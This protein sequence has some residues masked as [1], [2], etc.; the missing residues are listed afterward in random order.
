MKKKLL[1]HSNSSKL[2]TGFGRHM[3]TILSYLYS[4]GK[5]ELV[6]Y[7]AAPFSWS[8]KRL[9]S[10]PWK[11]FGA[12]PDSAN[13]V[14]DNL[15][16]QDKMLISYGLMN[17]DRVIEQEK[18]DFYFGIEDIWGLH[19]VWQRPWFNKI[20]SVLW[21]PVDSLPLLPLLKEAA[22]KSKNLWVKADFAQQELNKAGFNQVITVPALIDETP[23]FPLNELAR[24]QL[25]N[26]IGIEDDVFIVGFVFRNQI[27]KLVG[28]LFD[29]LR[30][31]KEKNPGAKIKVLLHTSWREGW[32]IRKLMEDIGIDH[33]D[34]ITSY[35]CHNC[36]TVQIM[37]YHGEEINC[38]AC[39][40]KALYTVDS[41]C[42]VTE[43]ELNQIY[44]LCDQY[45]HP[46]TSGGFEMPILE[47]IYAGVPAA[48]VPYSCGLSYTENKDIFPIEFTYY[49]DINNSQFLKS[50]PLPE[51]VADSFELFYNKTREE[52]VEIA[53]R[54]REWALDKFS[55]KKWLAKLEE[56]IDNTPVTNYD[57][58]Y[59]L[60]ANEEYPF[61]DNPDSRVFV[62]DL[63]K[64]IFNT[65][66]DDNNDEYKNILSGIE[67]GATH[68]KVYDEFITFA[69]QQNSS[70]RKLDLK[71]LIPASDNKKLLYVIPESLGDCFISLSVIEAII[72]EYVGWDIF[73]AS[74]E[75]YHDVF[76]HIPEVKGILKYEKW[77]DSFKNLEGCGDHEGIFDVSFHPYFLTQKFPSYGHNGKDINKLN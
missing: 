27:R 11:A 60:L 64:G 26:S 8:D 1:F 76:K 68:Q 53:S 51:S 54:V 43:N 4:T 73:I 63:Y 75:Q 29:G 67:K 52:R 38:P 22:S 32:D 49:R 50:Q 57:F 2:K 69:K 71:R 48:V 5:Y 19:S 70:K 20:N 37:H 34:V 35:I 55:S 9:K 62:R 66:I 58:N 47:A 28:T 59:S 7:A 56:F 13:E 15:T 44:N 12:L 18:P 10:L 65:S 72:K 30:I 24:K 14:K 31:F 61:S 33:Q 23:F 74:K 39:Q 46:M 40:K 6:E 42:G 21:T 3:K 36:K 77:M 41:S 17:L 25:R 45:C 16:E